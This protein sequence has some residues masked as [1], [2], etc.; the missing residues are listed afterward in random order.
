MGLGPSE[1]RLLTLSDFAACLEG[2]QMTLPGGQAA[3][4]IPPD[5]ARALRKELWG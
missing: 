1:V 2:H 4:P 5:E 3:A